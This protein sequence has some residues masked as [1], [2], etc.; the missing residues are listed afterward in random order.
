MILSF[1]CILNALEDWIREKMGAGCAYAFASS[2]PF[3]RQS[4]QKCT[5]ILDPLYLEL[6]LRDRREIFL[7]VWKGVG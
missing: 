5:N 1:C 7:S 4:V 6:L 3:F 2:V